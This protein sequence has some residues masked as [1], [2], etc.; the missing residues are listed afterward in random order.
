MRF[1]YPVAGDQVDKRDPLVGGDR[2]DDLDVLDLADRRVVGVDAER[3]VLVASGLAQPAHVQRRRVDLHPFRQARLRARS[4]P[5][6]RRRRPPGQQLTAGTRTPYAASTQRSPPAR[7]S[8]PHGQDAEAH[9]CLTAGRW[10]TRRPRRPWRSAR[11]HRWERGWR[12][13]EGEEQDRGD[14]GG[15]AEVD[16]GSVRFD[17]GASWRSPEKTPRCRTA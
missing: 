8:G 4:R 1:G 10:S 2:P 14:R 12:A 9:R 16:H 15:Q 5:R 11:R 17:Q 13:A 7:R 6:R 3:P